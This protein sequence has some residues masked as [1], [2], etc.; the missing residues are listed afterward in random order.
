M[1]REL[2]QPSVAIVSEGVSGLP[3]DLHIIQNDSNTIP[4][5]YQRKKS[6]PCVKGGADVIGGGIVKLSIC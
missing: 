4:Q 1:Q 3:F 2:S 5:S 6:P